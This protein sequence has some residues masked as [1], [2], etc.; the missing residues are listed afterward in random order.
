MHITTISTDVGGRLQD[1][2]LD[3]LEATLRQISEIGFTGAEISIHTVSA[4]INGALYWPQ[5]KRIQDIVRRFDLH[6]TAHAPNRLN[7]AYGEPAELQSQ[8]LRACLEFCNAIGADVLVYHSG[9]QALDATR[10][11]LRKLPTEAEL[12]AGREREVEALRTLAPIAA[13]YGIT[14]AMENGDPHL[15]EFDLLQT[16]G[17]P[18]EDIARYHARLRI[19]PIIAQIEAIDHPAV[20]LCLD[21]GHLYIAA[22]ALGFDY[23]EAVEQAAPWVRHLHANDNFG[24]LDSGFSGEGDRLPFGEGDLHLPPGWG[25]IPYKEVFARLS[26]Y[27]GTVVLEIK[28]RY[29]EHLSEVLA[30]T[31]ALV[32][33]SLHEARSAM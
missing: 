29:M 5:V 8:V 22:H 30:S 7:L 4:V 11:G 31:R 9:L 18:A 14:I 25:A 27:T 19:P 17:H 3:S 23:L 32:A 13:D 20:G 16:H 1:G 12:A 28:M 21:V 6:Y 26:G 10:A 24:K 15:W 2:R 33:E